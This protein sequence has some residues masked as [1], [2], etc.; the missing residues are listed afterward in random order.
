MANRV[1]SIKR[2]TKE[3]T[4]SLELDLDGSGTLGD[5]DGD[6]QVTKSDAERLAGLVEAVQ[7]ESEFLGGI[8]VVA[9]PLEPDWPATPFVVVDLRGIRTRW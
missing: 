5:L 1:S 9:K 4:I 8:G 3:T 2:E 7:R 6:G